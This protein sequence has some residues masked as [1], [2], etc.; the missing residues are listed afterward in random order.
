M[1][2]WTSS[3]AGCSAFS[4]ARSSSSRVTMSCSGSD[5]AVVS[6][7]GVGR[8]A[9]AGGVCTTITGGAGGA[10]WVTVFCPADSVSSWATAAADYTG[11][12]PWALTVFVIILVALFLIPAGSD[13]TGFL[14]DLSIQGWGWVWV[15][16]IPPLS[17]KAR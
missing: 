1:P 2:P 16:L 7:V 5:A 11:L 6:G 14:T 13:T 12:Q 4:M 15:I 10:V 17:G 3:G 8:G 9:G